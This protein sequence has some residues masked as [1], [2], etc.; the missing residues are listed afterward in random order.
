[1]GTGQN[2]AQ[3]WRECRLGGGEWGDQRLVSQP[4]GATHEVVGVL[5]GVTLV[6]TPGGL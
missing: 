2:S 5:V 3:Q 1:M 6:K 4:Q